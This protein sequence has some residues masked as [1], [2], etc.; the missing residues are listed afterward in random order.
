MRALKIAMAFMAVV[1]I[2]AMFVTGD[3][4]VVINGTIVPVGWLVSF[5]SMF[6]VFVL[7][8]ARISLGRRSER[9]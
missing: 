3:H 7:D 8:L 4:V 2:I 5:V 9:D 1:A 6:L